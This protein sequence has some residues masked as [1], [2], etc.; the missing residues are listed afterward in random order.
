[1]N[2][3]FITGLSTP[4]EILILGSNIYVTNFGLGTVGKYTTAG[5]VVNAS[6]ITGLNGASG[7]TTDGT[8]LFLTNGFSGTISEY[9]TSGALVNAA[10][11]SGLNG[12]VGIG[13]VPSAVPEPSSFALLAA[14]LACLGISLGKRRSTH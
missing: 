2:P 14:G 8:N 6:L 7:I 3:S 12:P 11:V 13:F 10:L 9:S 1:M 4:E 5:A